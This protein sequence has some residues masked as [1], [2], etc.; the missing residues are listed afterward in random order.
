MGNSPRN[1]QYSVMGFQLCTKS[2]CKKAKVIPICRLGIRGWSP[3]QAIQKWNLN[4]LHAPNL[5][6]PYTCT[7][8]RLW[9]YE[10]LFTLADPGGRTR[11][12]PPL[13]AAN[14][15]FFYVQNANFHN[16]FFARFARDWFL[17]IILIDIW[18]KHAKIWFLLQL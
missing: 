9:L 7:G 15:R 4:N 18:Q 14:L 8:K 2:H 5:N 12:A 11:R 1:T 10:L 6:A 3:S 16:F 13:T 17:S